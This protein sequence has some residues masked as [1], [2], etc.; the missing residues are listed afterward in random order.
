MG[1]LGVGQFQPVI[2]GPSKF[3]VNSEAV[4]SIALANSF[5]LRYV[6]TQDYFFWSR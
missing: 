3:F 6:A 1:K 5:R 4:Q 2:S